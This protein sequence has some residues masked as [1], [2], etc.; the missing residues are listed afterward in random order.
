MIVIAS[1]GGGVDASIPVE[2][3][4][5]LHGAGDHVLSLPTPTHTSFPVNGSTTGVPGRLD[6]DAADLYRAV[7]AALA[8]I[9]GRIA[10][11]PVD[12]TG[13]SLGAT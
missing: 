10:I 3:A 8:S 11:T 7:R 13:Y 12:L 1:T 6:Q 9:R 4:T 2:L 5:I